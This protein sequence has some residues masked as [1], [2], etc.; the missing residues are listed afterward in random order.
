MVSIWWGV[1]GSAASHTAGGSVKCS[2]R[3]GGPTRWYLSKLQ[4]H[5]SFNPAVLFLG[6]CLTFIHAHT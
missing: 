6:C 2:N 1:W 4:I 3:Y 5:E